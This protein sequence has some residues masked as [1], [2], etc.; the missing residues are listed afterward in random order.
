[1]ANAP[2]ITTVHF[3]AQMVR[4]GGGGGGRVRS[5]T[6]CKKPG[7]LHHF[8]HQTVKFLTLNVVKKVSSSAKSMTAGSTG[9]ATNSAK[10]STSNRGQIS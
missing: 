1:M 9:P 3:L 4:A 10:F 6:L 7:I 2:N 8:S 5:I